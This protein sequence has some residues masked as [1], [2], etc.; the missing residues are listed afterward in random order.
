MNAGTHA[1]MCLCVY[2]ELSVGK[3]ARIFLFLFP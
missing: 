2:D 1:A 3:I